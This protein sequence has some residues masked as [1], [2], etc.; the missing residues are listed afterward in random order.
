MTDPL[1]SLHITDLQAIPELVINPMTGLLEPGLAVT[2]MIAWTDEC[3]QTMTKQLSG[4]LTP[5]DVFGHK[6]N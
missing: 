2:V 6:L 1:L 5:K 3:G 4:S